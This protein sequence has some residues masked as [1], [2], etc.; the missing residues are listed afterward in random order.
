MDKDADRG[1]RDVRALHGRC[2]SVARILRCIS[3]NCCRDVTRDNLSEMYTVVKNPFEISNNCC[4]LHGLYK[5]YSA[6]L[7]R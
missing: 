4:T 7:Q 5:G 2:M 1:C 6:D 3:D